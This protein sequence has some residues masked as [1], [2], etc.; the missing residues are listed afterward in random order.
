MFF[1]PRDPVHD[2]STLRRR[3]PPDLARQPRGFKA[4]GD[5]EHLLRRR[6]FVLRTP[7]PRSMPDDLFGPAAP[8]LLAGIA[9]TLAPVAHWLAELE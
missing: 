1:I 3:D 7:S 5:W 2:S 4:A 6:H 8:E 9:A